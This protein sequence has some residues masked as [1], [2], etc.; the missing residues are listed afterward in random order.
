MAFMS[1]AVPP[2]APVR[3]PFSSGSDELFTSLV[4]SA[5]LP[6]QVWKGAW[7]SLPVHALA[8]ALIVLVPIFWPEPPP[9][10]PDYIKALI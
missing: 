5:P 1:G 7:Y 6:T 2:I 4:A 10:Q 8:L 3:R 9:E